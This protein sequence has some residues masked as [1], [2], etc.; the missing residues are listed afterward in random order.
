MMMGQSLSVFLFV[1][2]LLI[3]DEYSYHSS[4]MFMR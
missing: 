4:K 3:L 2:C 1:F